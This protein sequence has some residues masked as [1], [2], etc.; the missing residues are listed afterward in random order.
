MS[1]YQNK[2]HS[3]SSLFLFIILG[4]AILTI[5]L[6]LLFLSREGNSDYPIL[7]FLALLNGLVILI[8][9]GIMVFRRGEPK[10][11]FLNEDLTLGSNS[12]TKDHLSKDLENEKDFFASV[13]SHDL[14]SPLSSIILLTSYLKSKVGN[15]E[16]S[17]YIDLIEQSARKELEMMSTL[18]SLM[19]ADSYRIETFEELSLRELTQEILRSEEARVTKKR[20]QIDLAIA[21]DSTLFADPQVFKVILKNLI[22]QAICYSE[23]N[24]TIE[25][26][27][28][29]LDDRMVIELMVISE[30]LRKEAA[31]DLFNSDRLSLK[32]TKHEFPDCISLYFCQQAIRNYNGTIHV[33][34][35]NNLSCRFIMSLKRFPERNPV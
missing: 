19:R 20:L 33:Q 6:L 1:K 24:K 3:V 10:P 28:R 23:E 25:I 27:A 2:K 4:C 29:E 17:Q 34:V 13:L 5:T 18:L 7:L 15:P 35:E 26:S 31:S 22:V 11:A 16:S 8:V 32:T 14:R 9:C 12:E 30:E 21:P